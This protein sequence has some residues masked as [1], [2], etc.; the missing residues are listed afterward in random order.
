MG[1]KTGQSTWRNKQGDCLTPDAWARLVFQIWHD[2]HLV[3]SLFLLLIT[4]YSE[5]DSTQRRPVFYY[6]LPPSCFLGQQLCHDFLSMEQKE[7]LPVAESK[8]AKAAWEGMSWIW[9]AKYAKRAESTLMHSILWFTSPSQAT[10]LT[11]FLWDRNKP[12]LAQLLIDFPP[13]CAP[14][15]CYYYK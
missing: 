3:P 1:D 2:S 10:S 5:T 8:V 6:I 15:V 9:N 4:Q 14:C 13:I 11:V 12:W 7:E